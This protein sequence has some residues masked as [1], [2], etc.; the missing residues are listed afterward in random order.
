MKPSL[1]F[2]KFILLACLFTLIAAG[3]YAFFSLGF[4]FGGPY[5]N[6]KPIGIILLSI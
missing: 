5:N 4:C 2:V 3:L 6:L 1:F